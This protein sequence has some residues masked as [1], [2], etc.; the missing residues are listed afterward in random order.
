LFAREFDLAE[1][2]ARKAT[3]VPN[4]HYWGFSH[5]VAALGHLQRPDELEAAL[6][7]LRR[8]NPDFTCEFAQR[9]LFYVKDPDQ[10][11]LYISGLRK[12]GVPEGWSAVVYA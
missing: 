8:I 4:C 12:A 2:W 1:E 11:A 9:R 5:R 10:V 3:R 6:T 7:E